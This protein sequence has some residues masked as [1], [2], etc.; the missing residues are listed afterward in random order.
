MGYI[1]K[2]S[3]L[4]LGDIVFYFNSQKSWCANKYAVTHVAIVSHVDNSNRPWLSHI[5][6]LGLIFNSIVMREHE[7]KGLNYLVYRLRYQQDCHFAAE[8]SQLARMWCI[9]NSNA[10][11]I[12]KKTPIAGRASINSPYSSL[13]AISVPKTFSYF[14]SHTAILRS[15]SFGKKAIDFVIKLGWYR[16]NKTVP[17]ELSCK[18][19]MYCSMFVAA[20]YQAVFGLSQSMKML[21]IDAQT[22]MPWTLYRYVDD[23]FS[24]K[25]MGEIDYIS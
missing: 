25:R 20:C 11:L 21:A 19:G 8:A 15:A 18:G 22:V 14:K 23:N 10:Q 4:K 24:W 13:P 6:D 12:E 1:M 2:L 5:T 16:V 7:F 3:D 9:A 17:F